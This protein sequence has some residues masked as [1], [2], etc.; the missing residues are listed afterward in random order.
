[1]TLGGGVVVD[2]NPS[3][4]RAR[5]WASP[6]ASVE[7]RLSLALREAVGEGLDVADLPV[8]L[9]GSAHEVARALDAPTVNVV[10]LGGRIFD[11]SYR[12]SLVSVL[13]RAIDDH[14]KRHPLEPGVMLQSVRGQLGGRP[15]LVDDAVRVA[16]RDGAIQIDGGT[17]RRTGW[18]PHLSNND[19]DLKAKLIETLRS[20]GAEPPSVPELA[21]A[22]GPNVGPLLRLLEREGAVV[23]VESDRYYEAGALTLLV[24]QLRNGMMPGREYAPSE[25]RDVI[26]L[27]RKYLIPFLEYCDRR[28]ITERRLAGRV[29]HGT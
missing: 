9:G 23:P 8:R 10:G 29:L 13:V 19:T 25:L 16:V 4:R 20:A 26:G 1:V 12:D 2:P 15:E 28:G 14:H 5:P 6:H 18:T 17:V 22:H 21:S 27:S 11:P 24:G 7:S 3:H